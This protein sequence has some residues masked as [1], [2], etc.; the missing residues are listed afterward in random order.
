MAEPK[1]HPAIAYH[2]RTKH[3]FERFAASL[4]YLDWANQP[5]P[6]RYYRDCPRV[7]LPFLDQDPPLAFANLF[8][9]PTGD[10]QPVNTASVAGMAELSLALSAWKRY[11]D[12]QWAL[13][14]NPSS[15]NL[16][17]TESYWLL[18][19]LG[20][21]Y[22]YNPQWHDF[23]RRGELGA[24][25]G[26][27]L[28]RL[29]GP[30]GFLIAL[31]SIPWREAWKYGERAFRYC[32][33]DI[34]HALAALAFA[35]RLFGWHVRWL[36][37]IADLELET[38]LGFDRTHWPEREPEY[39]EALLW[40]GQGE[41]PGSRLPG[42]PQITVIGEPNRLSRDHQTWPI[43]D[44][45]VKDCR[46]PSLRREPPT[47]MS[48]APPRQLSSEFTA[49]E[50][51]RH[52]RSAQAFDSNGKPMALGDFL[53]CLDACLPRPG[54]APFDLGLGEANLDLFLFVHRVQDLTPGIYAL[55][56]NPE[57]LEPLRSHTSDDFAWK[58]VAEPLPLY[59][60]AEGDAREAAR[61]LS[62]QQD[63]AGD[64]A[65]SL[66]MIGRFRDRVT[67]DAST[68]RRLFWEAG[69]IGQVLY[70][71]AEACGLRGTGIGCYFDD[72]VH[73]ILGISGDDFQSLY[74][75][76]V[77]VPREDVRLTTLP[78]YHHLSRAKR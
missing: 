72:P 2:Q 41:P 65:F 3:H 27:T 17:P 19:Q 38:L 25:A 14:I 47:Q 29:C 7:E 61:L 26:E 11:G 18:P 31:S 62:C 59:R 36:P 46:A 69:M 10:P 51:I 45:T 23:A 56:R 66:G 21:L 1:S 40:V 49:A 76:T 57:H 64:S 6:F 43:I 39:G 13:R 5:D 58:P 44:R 60:L 8:H 28:C 67:A 16:H 20:G 4:G 55:I 77:G 70:L 32:N 34:G 9:P 30:Q 48:F 52:R 68:Y 78:P 71:M 50:I 37:E 24:Q 54:Q 75:F 42:L 33:H 53:D 12:N 74:H 35:A 73:Q 15:G 22:H 63:I